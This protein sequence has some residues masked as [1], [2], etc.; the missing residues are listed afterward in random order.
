MLRCKRRYLRN[1]CFSDVIGVHAAHGGTLIVYFEHDLG[2]PF[3]IH[4]KKQ[5]QYLNHE[6]HGSEIIV[7]QNHLIE[8]GRLGLAALQQR[9]VFL[10]GCHRS[11]FSPS[12]Q[13]HI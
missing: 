2:R 5:F 9:H 11:L 3:L 7:H 10:L 13:L 1:L 6:L 12:A 8:L 4:Q